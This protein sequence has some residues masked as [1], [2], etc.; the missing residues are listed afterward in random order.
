MP[1]RMWQFTHCPKDLSPAI[2]SATMSRL[3]VLKVYSAD[4]VLNQRTRQVPVN[5]LTLSV[6]TLRE[7]LG[8]VQEM[9]IMDS[10]AVRDVPV[11][12]V[13]VAGS[14][15]AFTLSLLLFEHLQSDASEIVVAGVDA[16]GIELNFVHAFIIGA[17]GA[18]S[19]R[20]GTDVDP[21]QRRSIRLD[22]PEPI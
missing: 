6:H 16:V 3:R 18:K 1:P 21:S 17:M 8:E 13:I 9:S 2:I 4:G 12:P 15:A 7:M 19:R 22:R 11:S 20:G 5:G 14:T 10:V